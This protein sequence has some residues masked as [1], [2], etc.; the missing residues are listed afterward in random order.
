MLPHRTP[1]TYCAPATPKESWNDCWLLSTSRAD[2]TCTL[3]QKLRHESLMRYKLRAA[4]RG[5]DHHRVK[6]A[7][8][9]ATDDTHNLAWFRRS[10]KPRRFPLPFSCNAESRGKKLGLLP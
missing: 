7:L 5:V 9:F 2:F 6:W 8:A 10:M 1:G 4:F 3:R